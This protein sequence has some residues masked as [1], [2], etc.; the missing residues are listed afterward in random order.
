VQ[1][2][3][4]DPEDQGGPSYS[5]VSSRVWRFI[6][7]ARR[8]EFLL[9]GFGWSTMPLHLVEPHL[10]NGDL[11]RLPID[12]PAI[13]PGSLPIYAVH[14]RNRPLGAAAQSLL[15]NL[16]QPRSERLLAQRAG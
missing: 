10:R 7:L 12:D 4:T 3:L 2:V 15:H 14:Q 13:L 16:Q 11:K 6:D 1:L 9:A 5:V 8:L